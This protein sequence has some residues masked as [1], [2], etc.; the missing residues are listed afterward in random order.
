MCCRPLSFVRRSQISIV[1]QL[2]TAELDNLI[3]CNFLTSWPF[4]RL[5]LPFLLAISWLFR[6]FSFPFYSCFFF[7]CLRSFSF[8]RGIHF[9]LCHF[10]ILRSGVRISVGAIDLSFLQTP[11]QFRFRPAAYSVTNLGS[12]SMKWSGRYVNLTTHL[13]KL[14]IS[15]A[16]PHCL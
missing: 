8:L 1:P 12:L 4:P 5:L 9:T 16:I 13:H 6:A 14:R 7:F 2:A 11:S 15:G 10:V 3:F